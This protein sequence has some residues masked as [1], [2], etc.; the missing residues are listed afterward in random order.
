MDLYNLLLHH[1]MEHPII[2]M[3]TLCL[4]VHVK[5]TLTSHVYTHI[6]LCNNSITLGT[7]PCFVSTV[8]KKTKHL[9]ILAS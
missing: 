1:L 3:H 4:K 9:T 2:F 7:L 5:L 8:Q 6:L